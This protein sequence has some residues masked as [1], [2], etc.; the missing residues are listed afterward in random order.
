[1]LGRIGRH[2][3]EPPDRCLQLEHLFDIPP[4]RD[5]K[6]AI[7]PSSRMTDMAE[8]RDHPYVWVTWLPELLLGKRV[9]IYGPWFKT[10]FKLTAQPIPDYRLAVRIT[11]HAERVTA[12]AE[13]L[14][15]A[16]HE[17]LVENE[18]AFKVRRGALTIGGRPDLIA[19]DPSGTVTVYDVKTG[20][21]SEAGSI[22]VMLYMALLPFTKP[23]KGKDLA[24]SVLYAG[25]GG[26]QE[27]PAS[28][29]DDA[30]KRRIGQVL[31]VLGSSDPPPRRPSEADC[32]FCSIAGS[33]CTDIVTEE[34]EIPAEDAEVLFWK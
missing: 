32:R 5:L 27:I 15:G 34:S 17:V 19:R 20:A 1:M 22:Q 25:G 31:D 30:F 13:A 28:A 12:L 33:E 16:H 6:W 10:H 23:F 26:H 18:N 21:P 4:G 14:T 9:C 2:R 11:D 24:G 3:S 29:V 8:K 7:I